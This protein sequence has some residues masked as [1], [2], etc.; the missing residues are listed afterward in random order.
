MD[1]VRSLPQEPARPLLRT[2]L[3]LASLSTSGIAVWL[4]AVVLTVLPAR[5]PARMPM[6]TAVA[7]GLAAYSALTLAWL[8]TARVR[9]ALLIASVPV[10]ALAAWVVI[11]ELRA[12]SDASRF[13][14][15]LLLMGLLAGAH[16]LVALAA[17][18]R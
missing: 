7:A 5:D 4:V 10:L 17:T 16:A 9:L 3:S 14:G 11:T 6:W 8:A 1:D 13:E 12:A 15:Y 18:R 2:L